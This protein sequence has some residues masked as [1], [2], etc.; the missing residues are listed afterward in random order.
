MAEA[1]RLSRS[2]LVRV[3]KTSIRNF[4]LENDFIYLIDNSKF[5]NINISDLSNPAILDSLEISGIFLRDIF[6]LEDYI[7]IS[8]FD[9]IS[10]GIEIIDVAE[11]S[12]PI[13]L[14]R[15]ETGANVYGMAFY[16]N[17]AFGTIDDY[18]TQRRELLILD[19]ANLSEPEIFGRFDIPARLKNPY[20]YN[21]LLFI[22]TQPDSVLIYDISNPI[23]PSYKTSFKVGKNRRINDINIISDYAYIST[24]YSLFIYRL[25]PT[26]IEQVAEIPS[27]FTLSP[28]YPNPFNAST[29]ISYSL[30]QPSTVSLDIYDILGRKVQTLHD[31][32]QSAGSHS[33]IWQAD[34]FSSG[35]YFYKLTAGENEQSEKMIL[36]K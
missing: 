30:P 13:S 4:V 22:N 29:N 11:P 23:S 34:G 2:T 28:N 3:I 24:L 31:G 1:G 32:R 21:D 35:M 16:D 9:T 14:G 36:L 18:W 26:G 27:Q 15:F 17:Y 20:V 8:V 10:A 25:T 5:Y 19:I 7:Y 33:L 6:K 12:N